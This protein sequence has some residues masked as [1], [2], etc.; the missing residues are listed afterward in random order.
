MLHVVQGSM[1][2]QRKVR[3]FNVAVCLC[4]WDSLPEA[5]RGILSESELLADRPI[6]SESDSRQ[7][8]RRANEVVAPFDRQY[9]MKQFPSAEIRIRR[10]AA[11]AVCYAVLPGDLFGA[12]GYFWELDPSTK[13]LHSHLIRDVFGNPFRPAPRIERAWREKNKGAAADM[14]ASIYDSRV[15]DRLP[16]LADALE[17][18][19]C[20]DADL[21]G[22]LRGPGPHVRGCWAVDLVLGKA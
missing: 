11:A 9:P 19:G 7:L 22:H 20:T 21:L 10:N 2:S 16:I 4:Y 8:C 13:E 17:D 14:S 15:F 12:A 18:A 3:L 6:Q 1:P 5:S